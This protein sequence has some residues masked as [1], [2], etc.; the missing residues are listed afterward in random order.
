MRLLD[1]FR[2]PRACMKVCM[3]G[4]RGVG[5]TTILTAVFNEAMAK[6]S[7]TNLNLIARGDT[8][9]RLLDRRRELVSIFKQR[10]EFADENQSKAGIRATYE[11]STFD[12]SFGLLGKETKLDL[13]IKDFPGEYVT[14][15]P[16]RVKEFIRDS[17]SILLAIDTPMLM[18]IA[19][20]F[21]E[22]KNKPDKIT[23]FFKEIVPT[24]TTEKLVMLIPLKC[25]K[26]AHEQRMSEVLA[27][28]EEKYEPLISL[29]K[30]N[31]NICCT[32]APIQTLGGVEFDSFNVYGNGNVRLGVDGCPERVNYKYANPAEYKPLF[33][34]Q[35]LYA[36]LSFVVAQYNRYKNKASLLNRLK[37]IVFSLFEKEENLYDEILKMEKFRITDNP[38][39]GYKVI[40]GGELFSYEK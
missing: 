30:S 6:I 27:T 33:C 28:V 3:M 32:I 35:P 11:E 37:M 9:A 1:F 8:G 5:K 29:L 26:Y 36:L 23:A 20:K 10:G 7:S 12:F 31:D 40:C 39:L 2:V 21:H 16:N 17:T 34:A 18:E 22:V 19:G 25:E 24:I 4:S 38:K 15:N 13:E 14:S